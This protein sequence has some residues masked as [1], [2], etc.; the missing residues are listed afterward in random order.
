[1]YILNCK[2][3]KKENLWIFPTTLY[4]CNRIRVMC[5]TMWKMS[6]VNL[7][8]HF[9]WIGDVSVSYCSIYIMTLWTGLYQG[10]IFH[11]HFKCHNDVS[12]GSLFSAH[13]NLKLQRE[14]SILRPIF[15]Y[16]YSIYL[17]SDSSSHTSR[18]HLLKPHYYPMNLNQY[19][20]MHT[21]SLPYLIQI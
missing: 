4:F 9:S 14:T 10:R 21:F 16:L 5:P 20:Q 19:T 11:G 1:M 13:S 17:V 15:F 8:A 7:K 18:N 2:W 3:T 6:G 12:E